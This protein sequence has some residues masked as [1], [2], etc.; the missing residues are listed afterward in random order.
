MI[1][2][3]L[4]ELKPFIGLLLFTLALWVLHRE[5]QAHHLRDILHQFNQIPVKRLGAALLLTIISYGIMTGYDVLALRFIQHPLSY[6]K[7]ALASFI[8][9][10]FSNNIGLSML[11]GAS[12]RYRLYSAWGLSGL[13]ITKIVFFCILAPVAGFLRCGRP[14]V[15]VGYSG[16]SPGNPSSLLIDPSFGCVFPCSC[17]LIPCG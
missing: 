2:H 14:G 12:V 4:A 6:G 7:I 15:F 3:K 16:T 5:L 13:E 1:K 9:Y 10:A 8:G 11:A 17:G